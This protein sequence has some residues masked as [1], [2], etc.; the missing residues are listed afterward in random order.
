[1]GLFERSGAVVQGQHYRT[2]Q[3]TR[4]LETVNSEKVDERAVAHTL[5]FWDNLWCS[6]LKKIGSP[7]VIAN[8]TLLL[9]QA[10]KEVTHCVQG[11]SPSEKAYA[12]HATFLYL[13]SLADG[14]RF[15]IARTGRG[16]VYQFNGR[17]VG[18]TSFEDG[19]VTETQF[20]RMDRSITARLALNALD[21][22]ERG[23]SEIDDG[24][25]GLIGL[26]EELGSDFEDLDQAP[27][28]LREKLNESVPDVGTSKS[29]LADMPSLK[30]LKTV[31]IGM[32]ANNVN[33]SEIRLQGVSLRS[34]LDANLDLAGQNLQRLLSMGIRLENVTAGEIEKFDLR[35]DDTGARI[36]TG[37][38]LQL[39]GFSHAETM[40]YHDKHNN[41]AKH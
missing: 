30:T 20:L 24:E 16:L 10:M 7:A 1:M 36:V 6:I 17:E 18:R 34:L 12:Q 19:K 40:A 31:V 5:G 13:Q 37:A 14:G 38:Q 23:G 35:T 32:Q 8:D 33:C 4:A 21:A 28:E 41:K 29:V 15:F 11:R 26:S 3:L 9:I 2:G 39:R 22:E 25:V 27:R